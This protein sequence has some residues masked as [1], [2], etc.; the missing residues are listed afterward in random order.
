M[1]V[2]NNIAGIYDARTQAQVLDGRV[3]MIIRL[4]K[5]RTWR[6]DN[7]IIGVLGGVWLGYF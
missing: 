3:D 4:E 5:F 6:Y 1:L 2:S 7:T